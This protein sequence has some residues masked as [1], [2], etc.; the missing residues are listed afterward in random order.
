[1]LEVHA[2]SITE[3]REV[4]PL[5]ADALRSGE[6]PERLWIDL[7]GRD[8]VELA[9]WLQDLGIEGLARKLCLGSGEQSGYFPLRNEILL[10]LPVMVEREGK[11]GL[12]HM[13]LLCRDDLLLTIHGSELLPLQQV[14]S[15]RESVEWMGEPTLAGLAAA[16]LIS[17]SLG[18]LRLVGELRDHVHA[19]ERKMLAEPSSISVREILA[20][21]GLQLVVETVVSDQLPVVAA[22]ARGSRPQLAREDVKE[23]LGCA[24]ANLEAADRDLERLE[25]RLNALYS[26]HDLY[27]Q[28]K[29]NR[30]LN[31]LTIL[32]ATMAPASLLAGIWGMNFKPMPELSVPGAYPLALTLMGVSGLAILAYFWRAGWFE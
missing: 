28:A 30:R 6:R 29:T 23:F 15:L 10:L 24:Q 21:R 7:K 16:I 13:V 31:L 9:G 3:S 17:F 5:E 8:P 18:N 11:P 19:L 1:M 27:A 22:L 4:V 32:T 26:G 20:E 25:N 2:F 14:G 12:D